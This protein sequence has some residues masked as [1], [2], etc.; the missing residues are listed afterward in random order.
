MFAGGAQHPEEHR[1]VDVRHVRR[2]GRMSSA[3]TLSG[4]ISPAFSATFSESCGGKR[5]QSARTTSGSSARRRGAAAGSD[6][7]RPAVEGARHVPEAAAKRTSARTPPA[8]AGTPRARPGTRASARRGRTADR[9]GAART[10]PRSSASDETLTRSGIDRRR[11]AP[12]PAVVPVRERNDRREVVPQ[13][14]PDEA[15]AQE[16]RR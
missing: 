5:L 10:C 15:V 16:R 3:W 13:V 9:R 4:S 6:R 2:Y 1:E 14:L 12:V 11:A 8:A 7:G